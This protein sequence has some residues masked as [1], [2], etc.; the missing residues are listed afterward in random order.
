MLKSEENGPTI[1]LIQTIGLI[2]NRFILCGF[3]A[4]FFVYVAEL[5]PTKIR[6]LGYGLTSIAGMIGS[7]MSPYIILFSK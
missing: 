6:S 2:L 3:W 5:Y 1:I 7:I 4:I